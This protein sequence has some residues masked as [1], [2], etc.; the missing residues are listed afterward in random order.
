MSLK[1]DMRTPK[2]FPHINNAT[3]ESYIPKNSSSLLS[4]N[5]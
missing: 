1:I 5:K 4:E 3:D 2:G